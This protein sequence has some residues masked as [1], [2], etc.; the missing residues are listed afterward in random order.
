MAIS[1]RFRAC[2][3]HAVD[4]GEARTDI[5]IVQSHRFRCGPWVSWVPTW[6][7]LRLLIM[8]TPL[9]TPTKFWQCRKLAGPGHAFKF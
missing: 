3:K 1:E 2:S 6:P 7:L 5:L 8:S 9:L 4:C